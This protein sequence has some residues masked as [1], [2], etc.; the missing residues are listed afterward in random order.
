MI[1]A[2]WLSKEER[3][4]G[5]VLLVCRWSD[6]WIRR[7][8][9]ALWWR[10]TFLWAAVDAVLWEFVTFFC[11]RQK[12]T[13]RGWCSELWMS[14]ERP[15]WANGHV[16]RSPFAT[17]LETALCKKHRMREKLCVS[18][19]HACRHEKQMLDMYYLHTHSTILWGRMFSSSQNNACACLCITKRI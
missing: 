17:W 1:A 12:A 4:P 7:R 11:C 8:F 10:H 3:G 5:Y 13:Y 6:D 15:P 14:R 16:G 2:S 19:F 18:A 9:T